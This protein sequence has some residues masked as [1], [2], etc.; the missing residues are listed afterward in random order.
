MH[1]N[2]A[3]A[4]S[5]FERR[6]IVRL[7]LGMC[8]AAVFSLAPQ[9]AAQAGGG[10]VELGLGG[11]L[12]VGAWNPLQV[13]VRDAAPSVLRLRIDEGSLLEGPRI[14]RYSASV[15]GG[16]GV[17]V[18]QDDLYLP[19]FRSLSWTLASGRTVLASGSL[20]PG[21]A[22]PRP[23]QIVLSASPGSWRGAFAADA[24]IVDVAASDLPARAAA[25]DGVQTLLLDGSAAAPRAASIA[26]AAAGGVQVMLAG[27]L[28]ASQ[29]SFA[30]LAGSG[31]ARLGAGVVERVAADPADVRARLA[32]WRPQDRSALV[33]ALASERLVQPPATPGQPL[34]LALAAAYALL[35]LLGLRF[36]GTPGLAAGLVLAIVVSLAGWR[37][38]RPPSPELS[39][40]RT[41]VLG[42][43]ELALALQVEERLT[44]PSRVASLPGAG[45][46]LSGLPYTVDD[47]VTHV[48]LPRWNAVAVA[49]RPMLRPAALR[50][51]DGRL[52][53]AGAGLLRDVYVLGLG[54]Q[55]DLAAGASRRPEPGEEGGLPPVL[56]RLSSLLPAGTALALAPEVV[57]V[58][59]PPVDP[60]AG[61]RP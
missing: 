2:L 15:P 43:G 55:P 48:E 7:A 13:T 25:F 40:S 14:V 32:A 16:S 10:R 54:R 45:H 26:A 50:F 5:A 47:G 23:L 58:A 49:A 30:R 28:P 29:A 35:A 37:L 11:H 27:A 31:A 41:V 42:G 60:G 9:A 61:G 12:V 36:G 57:W 19:A 38:L 3:T 46:P 4:G 53:N 51:E 18:F 6:S 44:L 8:L 17:T 52:A 24:R 34:V 20:G 22:D 1:M 59:L 33:Q 21:D 56:A 39:A